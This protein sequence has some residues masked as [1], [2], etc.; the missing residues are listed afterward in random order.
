MTLSLIA[1]FYFV[2]NNVN[3]QEA[4]LKKIIFSKNE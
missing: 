3:P 2:N 4:V 1:L